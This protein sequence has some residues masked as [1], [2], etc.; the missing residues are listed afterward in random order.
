VESEIIALGPSVPGEL[1][2]PPHHN[3][4]IT[5]DFLLATVAE[6]DHAIRRVQPTRG[7]LEAD[8]LTA[9]ETLSAQE[10]AFG[11]FQVRRCRAEAID[12]T[13]RLS[14]LHVGSR[15]PLLAPHPLP[16]PPKGTRLSLLP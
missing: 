12:N 2:H 16:T 10:R 7:A 8:G 14:R 4:I 9:A 13:T 6:P 11:G 1:V 3:P 15:P 5:I